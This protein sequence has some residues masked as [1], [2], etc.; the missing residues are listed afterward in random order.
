M[1]EV[2]IPN[3]VRAYSEYSTGS[4]MKQLVKKSTVVKINKK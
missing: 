1:F 4:L 3:Y 2:F